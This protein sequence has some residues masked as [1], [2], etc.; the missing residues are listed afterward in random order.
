[1]LFSL[2]SRTL[3]DNVS[4]ST[5]DEIFSFIKKV[6]DANMKASGYSQEGIVEQIRYHINRMQPSDQLEYATLRK[7]CAAFSDMTAIMMQAKNNI[8][9]KANSYVFILDT[10]SISENVQKLKKEGATIVEVKSMINLTDEEIKDNLDYPK[11]MLT[12]IEQIKAEAYN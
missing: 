12:F 10:D 5:K 1:M 2:V 7:H 9:S 3:V 4:D 8:N 6:I 11:M